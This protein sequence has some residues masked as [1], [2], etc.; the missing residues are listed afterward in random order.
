MKEFVEMLETM[1]ELNVEETPNFRVMKMMTDRFNK[2]GY[3]ESITP[4]IGSISINVSEAFFEDELLAERAIVAFTSVIIK[5]KDALDNNYLWQTA[6]P[7]F[8]D[9]LNGMT[10]EYNM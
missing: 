4:L 9:M 6:N 2:S 10:F 1:V 3:K 8:K 5:I 7:I